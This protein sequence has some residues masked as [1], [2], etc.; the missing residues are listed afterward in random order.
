MIHARTEEPTGKPREMPQGPATS[1][2][3]ELAKAN[4]QEI[5]EQPAP[6]PAV[7]PVKVIEKPSDW[8]D[9]IDPDRDCRVV[10]E[11]E[12]NRATISVPGTPHI[13]SAEIARVNAPRILRDIKG[14]FDVRVRVMG[15]GHP[16]GRA[17]TTRYAPYHGAGILIWQDQENYLRLEIAADLQRG[18]IRPYVNFEYRKD[19]ALAVSCGRNIVDGSTHLRLKRRGDQLY[20]AFGPDG[21]RWTSFSPL[22]ASLKERLNV[23]VSAI[24]TATKAP[25]SGIGRLRGR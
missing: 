11:S 2:P 16:G 21:D 25:D 5:P 7:Q 4:R 1:A 17:T 24:N 19:G 8:G 20:A 23:G 6:P 15:T 10:V 13:L 18:K 3:N 14:D 22:S 12:R 9:V